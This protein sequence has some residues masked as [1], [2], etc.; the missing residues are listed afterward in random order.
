M[1]EA[2]EAKTNHTESIVLAV[3]LYL[4]GDKSLLLAKLVHRLFDDMVKGRPPTAAAA[5]E[6]SL[7]GVMIGTCLVV[8][9]TKYRQKLLKK[10][11]LAILL[12]VITATIAVLLNIAEAM[13]LTE[14]KYDPATGKMLFFFGLWTM[15]VVLPVFT[16]VAQQGNSGDLDLGLLLKIVAALLAAAI[17]GLPLRPA[18]S[19]VLLYGLKV[20]NADTLNAAFDWMRFNSDSL[21]MLGAVWWVAAF[22]V[23]SSPGGPIW[24][25][26]YIVAAPLAG[27]FYARVLSLPGG[28]PTYH[29]SAERLALGFAVLSFAA[30]L[31]G[32]W[33]AEKVIALKKPA[34]LKGAAWTFALCTVAMY[35]GLSGTLPLD[36]TQRIVVSLLQGLAGACIP[37]AVFLSAWFLKRVLK[38]ESKEGDRTDL[39]TG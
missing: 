31:P 24:R 17:V 33:F 27:F 39:K 37:V 35:W 20:G 38:Q 5:H 36:Q 30:I 29:I 19:A 18:I 23:F 11:N 9:I 13:V 28:D 4:L 6:F 26:L 32:Y 22:S 1:G 25:G 7:V 15:L 21:I 3:L 34:L 10:D 12:G 16:R 2:D 14:E 8:L